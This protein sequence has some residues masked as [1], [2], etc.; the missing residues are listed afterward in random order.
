MMIRSV[1]LASLWILL[2]GCSGSQVHETVHN[3]VSVGAAPS[4]RID[5]AVG[6][7]HVTGWQ[8]NTIDIKAVK[9]GM[10]IQAVRNIDIDVQTNGNDVT[11]AT[12]YHGFGNGGVAYTISVPAGASLDV[13]NSTGEIRIDGVDGDVKAVAQTGS[14]D[15]NVGRVNGQR[16]IDLT[17]TTGSI[18]LA[19]GS[20]S[21]ARVDA[22]AS[23][24]DVRS[25]FPSI[26]SGRQNVVGASAAGTIGEGSGSIRLTTTT[27]SIA[28]RQS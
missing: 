12:K 23:V 19:I 22:R 7:I 6:A 18:R 25:D 1:A 17:A 15:A 24:G 2:Y 20:H 21:D 5:N 4:V 16:S 14:V 26:V 9:D 27:G 13:T 10:S 11:I 28:L 3:S 8:K